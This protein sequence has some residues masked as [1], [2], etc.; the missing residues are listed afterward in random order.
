MG[1]PA[2]DGFTG[3]YT[4]VKDAV[5]EQTQKTQEV[6]VPLLHRPGEARW[7]SASCARWRF[8]S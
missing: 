6:F 1:A 3:G 4:V 8:S 5:R 7:T 2:G